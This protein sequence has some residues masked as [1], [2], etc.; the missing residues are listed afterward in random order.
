MDDER[1]ANDPDYRRLD[2]AALAA[3]QEYMAARDAPRETRAR[4][5]A[6]AAGHR[7]AAANLAEHRRKL[8]GG[9]HDR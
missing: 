6:A 3:W 8:Q 9:A 2:R 1:I 5:D 7:A 4:M